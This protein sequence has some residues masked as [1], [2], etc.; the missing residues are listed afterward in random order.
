MTHSLV[1]LK[2]KGMVSYHLSLKSIFRKAEC[3][4]NLD[5]IFFLSDLYQQIKGCFT[6]QIHCQKELRATNKSQIF[7][8]I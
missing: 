5:H 8:L 7:E 1:R 2:K 4:H 3:R 6:F